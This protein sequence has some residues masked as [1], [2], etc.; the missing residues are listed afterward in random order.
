[1]NVVGGS[2]VVER[3]ELTVYR[4]TVSVDPKFTGSP[5]RSRVLRA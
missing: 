4:K 3:A 5:F 2:D 1:M